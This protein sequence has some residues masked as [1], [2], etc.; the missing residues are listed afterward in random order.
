RLGS[1]ERAWVLAANGVGPGTI[2]TLDH[3]PPPGLSDAIA[4]RL[5]IVLRRQAQDEMVRGSGGNP[6]TSAPAVPYYL[7]RG[8]YWHGALAG[9]DVFRS[10]VEI[11][12]PAIHL[13]ANAPRAL[14]G[15]G[16][17]L[18]WL[19]RLPK[20]PVPRVPA[21]ASIPPLPRPSAVDPV[22]AAGPAPYD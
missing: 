6:L 22:I 4:R 16:R 1:S 15:A 17:A 20:V 18:A 3:P 21:S 12:E 8:D 9:R 11:K 14:A 2:P 7:A 10:V 5:E 13:L 19:E